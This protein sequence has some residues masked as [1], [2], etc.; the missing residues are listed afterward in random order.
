[1]A[2]TD[3][4]TGG[5]VEVGGQLQPGDGQSPGDG[6]GV[7]AGV[8]VEPTP[9]ELHDDVPGLV[10]GDEPGRGDGVG[11]GVRR[12]PRI[13]SAMATAFLSRATTILDSVCSA[14]VVMPRP[15][16]P[17]LGGPVGGRCG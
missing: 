13:T 12:G 1:M 14:W 11:A 15:F 3:E 6:R 7:V 16:G 8:G 17:Q 10:G 5:R 4:A 2:V 9:R